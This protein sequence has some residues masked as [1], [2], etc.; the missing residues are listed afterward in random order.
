MV[1]AV[2]AGMLL[3][4]HN[5]APRM[6]GSSRSSVNKE[7]FDR[8]ALE[9]SVDGTGGAQASDSDGDSGDDTVIAPPVDDDSTLSTLPAASQLHNLFQ[10]Y[11]SSFTLER[12]RFDKLNVSDPDMPKTAPRAVPV[13]GKSNDVVGVVEG[14]NACLTSLIRELFKDSVITTDMK[15]A[16]KHVVE[17]R[18]RNTQLKP[19]G[20]K[21]KHALAVFYERLLSAIAA[22][23]IACEKEDQE[24][25]HDTTSTRRPN[26]QLWEAVTAD[27]TSLQCVFKKGARIGYLE[28]GEN[29]IEPTSAIGLRNRQIAKTLR[30]IRTQERELIRLHER[31]AD[32]DEELQ[33]LERKYTD[34]KPQLQRVNANI[35]FLHNK[36]QSFTDIP[37]IVAETIAAMQAP[38]ET[39]KQ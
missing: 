2:A 7:G 13:P 38:Q 11:T 27:L 24:A 29:A 25:T 21:T 30:N 37:L 1:D 8:T 26:L 10:T 20:P 22:L 34:V 28:L 5:E 19:L 18:M 4:K 39:P 14:L 23:Q 35:G 33:K 16:L 3:M 15:N 32:H 31:Q 36:L 17:P 6:N 12:I 9:V